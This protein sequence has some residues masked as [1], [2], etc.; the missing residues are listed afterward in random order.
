MRKIVVG[1][2]GVVSLLLAGILAWDAGA[3]PLTGT[4]GVQPGPNYSFVE[5]AACGGPGILGRCPIGQH[6]ICLAPN[7]C[8]CI[9]CN[10]ALICSPPKHLINING[11]WYCR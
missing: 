8:A 7:N 2:A 5:K 3:T 4:I 11:T 9:D 1:I 6:W 10:Q